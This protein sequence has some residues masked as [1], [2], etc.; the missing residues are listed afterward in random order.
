M[1]IHNR[2]LSK[3]EDTRS[4]K[5][6]VKFIQ[7]LNMINLFNGKS[8]IKNIIE[9]GAG[10]GQITKMLYDD[11]FNITAV[12]LNKKELKKLN[13][14]G[15]K[16][17][18]HDLNKGCDFGKADL[19]L[20]I[21]IIEHI[22]NLEELLKDIRK[23]CKYFI[24]AVPNEFNLLAKVRYFMEKEGQPYFIGNHCHRYHEREWEKVFKKYGFKI[25][26]KSYVPLRSIYGIPFKLYP[27][28]FSRE[29][30]YVME[31]I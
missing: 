2:G 22:Y 4:Y 5:E 7:D 24:C 21:A 11:L 8:K 13:N 17:I 16:T 10:R 26:H 30:K 29:I 6:T 15:I 9:I 18:C 23:N 31:V 19:Y 1:S 25:K 14:Y 27:R 12:D 20:G 28:G 3:F